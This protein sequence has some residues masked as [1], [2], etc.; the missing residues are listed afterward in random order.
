[1][2]SSVSAPSILSPAPRKCWLRCAVSKRRDVFTGVARLSQPPRQIPLSHVVSRASC[3]AL[4]PSLPVRRCTLVRLNPSE[5]G[6]V[7]SFRSHAPRPQSREDATTTLTLGADLICHLCSR[8]E[9][10]FHLTGFSHAL[11]FQSRRHEK[12]GLAAPYRS[13]GAS[14]EVLTNCEANGCSKTA[15]STSQEDEK[16]RGR[17]GI[18]QRELSS[19]KQSKR[20]IVSSQV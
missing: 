12:D 3:T 15:L 7:T 4:I 10:G 1:M 19:S 11:R 18:C 17:E 16:Q 20:W 14:S 5:Y 9:P 2:P 6:F 8:F 13:V